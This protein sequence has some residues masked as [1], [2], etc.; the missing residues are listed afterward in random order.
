MRTPAAGITPAMT[1]ERGEGQEGG[2]AVVVVVVAVVAVPLPETNDSL[3]QS[4]SAELQC[5]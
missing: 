4:V 2:D 3:L 5:L 1:A